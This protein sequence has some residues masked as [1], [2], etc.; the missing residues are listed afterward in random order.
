MKHL[1]FFLLFAFLTVISSSQSSNSARSIASSDLK[2]FIL[3]EKYLIT[4]K[5]L[6][7]SRK[8]KK[9]ELASFSLSK[10]DEVYSPGYIYKL[11]DTLFHSKGHLV[12]LLGRGSENENIV[13]LASYGEGKKLI[14]YK[15]V[16]YDNSEGFL[17]VETVI[18]NNIA[19]ITTSNEYEE[20]KKVITER[21]RLA[22]SYKLQKVQ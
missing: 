1:L 20:S 7:K 15:Q 17:L 16:Y 4:G 22:T 9:E 13:W 12:I 3:N 18:R 11:I 14:D 6:S 21:Y 5:L 8:L 10:I 2:N 19:S